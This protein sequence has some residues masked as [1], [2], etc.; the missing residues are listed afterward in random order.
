MYPSDESQS[1]S[2]D[3]PL[4]K[5]YAP[6]KGLIFTRMLALGLIDK[7]DVLEN[8]QPGGIFRLD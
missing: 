7:R 4:L 6:G 8:G 3:L 1:R 5:Q 2:S